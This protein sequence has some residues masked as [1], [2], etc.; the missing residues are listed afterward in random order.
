MK[1]TI[2]YE[3][4]LSSGAFLVGLIRSSHG[5][6]W[7]SMTFPT[8]PISSAPEQGSALREGWRCRPGAWMKLFN[9]LMLLGRKGGNVF[10]NWQL[11]NN[12][13]T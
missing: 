8:G 7:K 10:N 11:L 3:K 6:Q 5:L 12:I 4:S 2:D 13:S 1:F 9:R